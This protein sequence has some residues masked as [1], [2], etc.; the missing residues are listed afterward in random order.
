MIVAI[1]TAR[2][3][4]KGIPGKNMLDIGGKPLLE[5]TYQVASDTKGFDR[6]ILSTDMDAAIVHAN[7]FDRIDVPFKRPDEL[8][9]DKISQVDVVNHALAS[10]TSEN[11]PVTGFVL[12]QPTAPFRTV[13]EMEK[14]IAMLKAGSDSVLGVT[15]VMHHPADYLFVNQAGKIDFLMKEF[16]AKRRQDFPRVLFNNGA[17]YGCSLIYF[18]KHQRFYDE[19]SAL[20]EMQEN[21][22]IDI[23]TEFDIKLA[24][25]I[26]NN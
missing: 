2:A 8:C 13:E 20:L 14:G 3:N 22:L 25:G 10:L 16:L 12:L 24:K 21:S 6:I 7:K 17:F 5:Y 18:T 4:S 15:P 1:I 11:Y 9:G 23:D 26:L 19:N